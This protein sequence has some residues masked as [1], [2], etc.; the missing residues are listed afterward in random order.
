MTD[1]QDEGERAPELPDSPWGISSGV[2]FPRGVRQLVRAL[3]FVLGIGHPARSAPAAACS[4]ALEVLSMERAS[5]LPDGGTAAGG[6]TFAATASTTHAEPKPQPDRLTP[7][8]RPSARMASS[9]VEM[10]P[11]RYGGRESHP[12]RDRSLLGWRGGAQQA[13]HLELCTGMHT[14]GARLLSC[15]A[16]VGVG[17]CHGRGSS[18]PP[19]TIAPARTTPPF[20]TL[21]L[22]VA[23]LAGAGSEHVS[24]QLA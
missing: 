13:E 24:E 15:A 9:R 18:S 2:D 22:V 6:A 4:R 16:S 12:P 8:V 23:Q 1:A 21:N 14:H 7:D 11:D 10:V 17:W 19:P 5:P 20:P 3:L